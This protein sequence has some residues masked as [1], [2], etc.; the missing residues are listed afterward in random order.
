RLCEIRIIDGLPAHRAEI[1]HL[2]P[3]IMQLR[4]QAAFQIEAPVIGG[5]GD[6]FGHEYSQAKY[7]CNHTRCRVRLSAAYHPSR[8]S[9]RRS[10]L[11]GAR[12]YSRRGQT[13]SPPARRA[14]SVCP[15]SRR[16]FDLVILALIRSPYPAP[17]SAHGYSSKP[18]GLIMMNIVG[19]QW[20]RLT[21]PIHP[22]IILTNSRL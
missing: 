16:D 13:K 15:A 1:Q 19:A 5:D 3:E 6:G 8:F 10:R 21:V 22:A 9:C 2:V 18:P 17:W 11:Y 4:D 14:Y 20:F 12:Q 7:R